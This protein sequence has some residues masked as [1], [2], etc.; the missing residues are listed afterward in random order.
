MNKTF[1][2]TIKI[3][4]GEVFHI[5]YHQKRYESVL[6]DFSILEIKDLKSFINPP[7]SGL[8]RCRLTYDLSSPTQDIKVQYM[9]YEKK[10][11]K[12]L[13]IIY[14]NNIKYKHKSTCRD[15]IDKLYALRDNCDDII[16]VKDS[17]LTDTSIANIAFYTT[18]EWITPKSPLL[19]G[20]TRQ[21]LIDNGELIES[22]IKVQDIKKF[23]KI[24]LLNA[25]IGFDI[26]ESCEFLI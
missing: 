16:I 26:L 2:E 23:T 18:N 3:F 19:K 4:D 10:D 9:K 12:T 5:D 7:K 14:D 25:M 24:A 11:V 17:L 6:K 13:K 20:T 8:Y 15:K 1:L 22:D 21:R